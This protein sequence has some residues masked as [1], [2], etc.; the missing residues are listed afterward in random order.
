MADKTDCSVPVSR[1]KTARISAIAII[2]WIV[3]TAV[4]IATDYFETVAIV[5]L[6]TGW[7]VLPGCVMALFM[8]SHGASVLGSIAW[9]AVISLLIAALIAAM[10]F[11]AL[12]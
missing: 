6:L 5:A 7:T 10:P 9:G 4:A 1:L 3:G 12:N 2:G 8:S 11:S